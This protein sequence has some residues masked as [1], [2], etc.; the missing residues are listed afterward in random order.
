MFCT[1]ISVLLG[2]LPWVEEEARFG[3]HLTGVQV[4]QAC[5]LSTNIV[6]VF[7]PALFDKVKRS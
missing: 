6:E 2:V 1:S 5:V 4:R 7:L 3:C